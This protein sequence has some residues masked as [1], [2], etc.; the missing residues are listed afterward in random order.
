MTGKHNNIDDFFKDSFEGFEAVPGES[1]WN[2]ISASIAKRKTRKIFPFI[3]KIAAGIA[4]LA[5]LGT[6]MFVLF[7]DKE[8]AH[9]RDGFETRLSPRRDGFETPR[10]D[11]FETPR[12]DGF[13]TPRRDGFE[14]PR[15][16]GFETRLYDGNP[17][18]SAAP[19]DNSPGYNDMNEI[20][21][22]EGQVFDNAAGLEIPEMIRGKFDK[23][24]QSIFDQ[25]PPEKK[26]VNEPLLSDIPAASAEKRHAGRWSLGG[27]FAPVYSYRHI[28]SGYLDKQILDKYNSSERGILSWS[29]G[30]NILYSASRRLELQSGISFSKFGQVNQNVFGYISS[31]HPSY[32]VIENST[33]DIY[34]FSNSTGEISRASGNVEF[35]TDASDNIST[36]FGN[37]TPGLTAKQVFD[38]LELPL[39]VK[40]KII[41]R[42]FGVSI[43]GGLVTN[44]MVGNRV[45]IEEMNGDDEY[46]GKTEKIREINYMAL[47]G[48]GFGFPLKEGIRFSLEPR[49]RYYLNPFDETPRLDVHPY[50]FGI[51]SGFSYTF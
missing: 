6:T 38:Y 28:T 31:N 21:F 10:R 41:D 17:D 29:G 11:G 2:N 22:S 3:L 45:L 4:L 32:L 8:D 23:I 37:I 30:I 18:I 35:N 39:I 9:R 33:N 44:M 34:S 15:R 14:T 27:E 16:D 24:L 25:N 19:A 12:R 46:F 13:E 1:V 7:P 40:Y 49:F 48:V 26:H 47:V 20:A 43:S 42:K 36:S 51:Y 5:A 50:A